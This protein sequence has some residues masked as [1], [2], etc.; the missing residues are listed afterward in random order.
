LGAKLMGRKTSARSL[1]MSTLAMVR[2]VLV[3]G[4]ETE[5]DFKVNQFLLDMG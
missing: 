4:V 3:E 5:R 2:P 1:V